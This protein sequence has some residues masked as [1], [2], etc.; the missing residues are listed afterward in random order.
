MS[1][2][3]SRQ[4]A[5]SAKD[6][7]KH[8]VGRQSIAK[9]IRKE[10]P[11]TIPAVDGVTLDLFQ[12]ETLGLV[13]ESGCGKSTLGRTLVG[14]YGATSGAIYLN[15]EPVTDN[16]TLEQRRIAQMIFQDP[17]SSLN[18]QMTIRKM[19]SEILLFHKLRS[20]ESVDAR[21]EELMKVVGLPLATLDSH[22]RQ[23]S[24]GQRQRIGIARA[25]ALEP[26]ILIADEAVSA[27][28]VSVQ[29]TIVNLLLDLRRD[30]G[31]SILFISHNIAVVRQ[32]CDRI[33]V[34]Y[35]GR[36]VEIG[37][38]EQVFK[39]PRHPYTKLL[40][41]SVPK[42]QANSQVANLGSGELPSLQSHYDGCRFMSRCSI[43]TAECAS[44]DPQLLKIG[45]H[46]EGASTDAT[47]EVACIKVLS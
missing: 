38:T 24:G 33:A 10:A 35:L 29:A 34:M 9:K 23:F 43:A 27:L 18:P 32:M 7:A 11:L 13:G 30:L 14:L 8:F 26:K 31:L 36:I 42:M 12:G 39:E 45:A 44:I 17:F 46:S 19:L 3:E 37:T 21:C 40:L 22:P 16:R 2:I 5:L 1:N 20:K 28:D 15:G 6:L 25:L 47:H 4:V 41:G